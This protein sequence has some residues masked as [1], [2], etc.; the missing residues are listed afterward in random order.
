MLPFL[1]MSPILLTWR[2]PEKSRM[3]L[4][5]TAVV[6]AA[7]EA[8]VAVEQAAQAAWMGMPVVVVV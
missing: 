2:R 8:G 4:H 6:A 5:P 7:A 3:T 1:T